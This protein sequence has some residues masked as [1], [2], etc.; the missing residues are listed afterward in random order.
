MNVKDCMTNKIFTIESDEPV[1]RAWSL[2]EKY[3]LHH[4][5][6]QDNHKLVGIISDKDLYKALPSIVEFTDDT[7]VKKILEEVKVKDVM[8]HPVQHVTP[9]IDIRQVARLFMEYKFRCFPVVSDNTLVGIITTTD[10]LR[11]LAEGELPISSGT[12]LL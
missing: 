10:L 11:V 3:N 4:I 8:S 1:G 2:M 6:V 12:S 5:P 7:K 9:E